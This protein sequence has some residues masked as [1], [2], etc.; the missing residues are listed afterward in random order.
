MAVDI[1]TQRLYG[2]C[3]PGLG[4]TGLGVLMELLAK[5]RRA[6]RMLDAPIDLYPL[7]FFT[8]DPN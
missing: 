6:L 2:M 7:V 4:D 8:G 5:L 1:L 3:G